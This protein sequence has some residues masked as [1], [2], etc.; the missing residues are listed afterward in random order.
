MYPT[1]PSHTLRD[2][3][4][5]QEEF[6]SSPS[7]TTTT[8][9]IDTKYEASKVDDKEL[10]GREQ[11]GTSNNISLPIQFKSDV[12]FESLKQ[13]ISNNERTM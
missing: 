11:N 4:E 9:V 13:L 1:H 6:S 10:K 7:A 8:Q 2:I 5:C 3:I 12:I